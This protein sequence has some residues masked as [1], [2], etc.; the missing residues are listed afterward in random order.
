MPSSEPPPTSYNTQQPINRP[1]GPVPSQYPPPPTYGTHYGPPHPSH[2]PSQHMNGYPPPGIVSNPPSTPYGSTQQSVPHSA[3]RYPDFRPSVSSPAVTPPAISTPNLDETKLAEMN[4]L[5]AAEV[6]R[7]EKKCRDI[8]DTLTA[9]EREDEID[10]QKRGHATR[11]SQIRKKYGIQIRTSKYHQANFARDSGSDSPAGIRPIATKVLDAFRAPHATKEPKFIA[12]TWSTVEQGRAGDVLADSDPKRRRLEKS[13]TSFTPSNRADPYGVPG[14][15]HRRMST[16]LLP[17]GSR[18]EWAVNNHIRSNSGKHHSPEVVEVDELSRPKYT[19]NGG[20]PGRPKSSQKRAYNLPEGAVPQPKRVP[21]GEAQ[22]KWELLQP[23]N[24]ATNSST[25][26]PA[27]QPAPMANM[28][29]KAP[30]TTEP[31]LV[32]SSSDSSPR[33]SPQP[34]PHQCPA[35]SRRQSLSSISNNSKPNCTGKAVLTPESDSGA[36]SDSDADEDIP[37]KLP[38]SS[39]RP[40]RM[41]ST[42]LSASPGP[43]PRSGA[44]SKSLGKR[45]GSVAFPSSLRGRIVS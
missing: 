28:T 20:M 4:E 24:S 27:P 29:A 37:A 10:K 42:S 33:A 44:P 22:R 14:G 39:A 7:F 23:K 31:V 40:S 34:A 2:I 19:P 45:R 25:S 15:F 12:S 11:K 30:T 3:P 35:P 38:R 32:V 13:S 16:T 43:T 36:D 6:A 1:N 9:A 26:P 8:P 41:S 18:Q 17:N 5:I 21:I